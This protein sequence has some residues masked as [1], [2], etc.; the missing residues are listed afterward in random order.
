VDPTLPEGVPQSDLLVSRGNFLVT[1]L[2][3]RQLLTSLSK[4]FVDMPPVLQ[5][6]MALTQFGTCSARWHKLLST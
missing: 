6:G 3:V 5:L 2:I 4:Y 1:G